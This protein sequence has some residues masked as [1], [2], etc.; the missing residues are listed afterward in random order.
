MMKLKKSASLVLAV[1]LALMFTVTAV[2][3]PYQNY[4][5]TEGG[6]YP[7]PQAYTPDKVINSGYIGLDNLDGKAI[8][9]PQ[10][11]TQF[12]GKGYVLISDTGN[13]RV[14]VL[15]KDIRTV[16]RCVRTEI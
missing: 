12:D 9:N 8:S 2:A 13:N 1:I 4:T 11:L 6:I 10:D 15:D 5:I 16:N 14:I 3:A 7:D